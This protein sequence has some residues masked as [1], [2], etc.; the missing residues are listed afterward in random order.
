MAKCSKL[1]A[2]VTSLDSAIVYL[3]EH[4]TLH[5]LPDYQKALKFLQDELAKASKALLECLKG[6]N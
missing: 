5:A 6:G 2:E 4:K 3:E 1:L